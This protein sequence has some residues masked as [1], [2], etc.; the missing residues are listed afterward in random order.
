MQQSTAV[1]A[2]ALL[3]SAHAIMHAFITTLMTLTFN[4]MMKYADDTYILVGSNHVATAT[5]EFANVSAWAVK[6]NL[7][8]NQL[9]TRELVITRRRHKSNIKPEGPVVPAWG[10][11]G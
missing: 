8:L 6:N 7:H 2:V 3:R 5:A 4:A 10:G 1:F 11:T 9:K